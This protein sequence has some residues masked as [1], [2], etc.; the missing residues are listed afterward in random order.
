MYVCITYLCCYSTR[1]D[2]IRFADG[3]LLR[4]LTLY[5]RAE[6]LLFLV[7]VDEVASQ[8][9]PSSLPSLSCLPFFLLRCALCAS[10][11]SPFPT[12]TQ[13]VVRLSRAA[14]RGVQRAARPLDQISRLVSAALT[15][16]TSLWF[17]RT[18]SVILLPL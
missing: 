12:Q 4:Y 5:S 17:R 6:H 7:S 11:S 14:R 10:S 16:R 2:S 8:C 15:A 18:G 1:L 9:A 3:P 13:L